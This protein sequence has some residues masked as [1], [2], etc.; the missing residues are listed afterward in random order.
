[1]PVITYAIQAFEGLSEL[2]SGASEAIKFIQDAVTALKAMQ[3]DG[4]DPTPE[5]WDAL[6][7][8]IEALRS[9]LQ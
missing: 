5:E 3:A 7:A 8:Q 4:R 2:V 1:M 6:D 9:Q